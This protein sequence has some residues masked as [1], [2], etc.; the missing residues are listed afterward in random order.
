MRAIIIWAAIAAAA[1]AALQPGCSKSPGAS[2]LY[3]LEELEAAAAVR[4]PADRMERLEIFARNHPRHP[5]RVEAFA[6]MLETGAQLPDSGARA[7][8]RLDRA[9][10]EESDPSI[11]GR[12]LFS[13]FEFLWGADSLRAVDLARGVA[14]G[15]QTDFRLLMYLAYYLMDADGQEET[16]DKVFTRLLAVAPDTLRR[17]H[18]RTVYAEF[19]ERRGLAGEAA[20]QLEAAAGYPFADMEL[21][22]RLWER[23]DRDAAI[24]AWIRLAARVPGAR[25]K[26]GL[27]SLYA[28]ADPGAG[29]LDERIADA[30]IYDGP[31]LPGRTFVDIG[32]TVHSLERL[33]GT[34]LVIVAF[35]PT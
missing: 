27:D 31:R 24:R 14:A 33:R 1:G 28:I 18:A 25:T 4:D 17:S 34:K 26:V 35:S 5:Y 6:K 11:R 2:D 7:L 19:L 15:E 9:I 29:D 8:E 23:G 21:A 10:G 22:P 16:A 20:A 30:R 32:G 13:K 3:I 12:L